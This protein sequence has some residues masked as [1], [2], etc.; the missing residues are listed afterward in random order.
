MQLND[1]P[2]KDGRRRRRRRRGGRNRGGG[3]G[4]QKNQNQ[5]RPPR[6]DPSDERFAG[7]SA[8]VPTG[9]EALDQFN[10]FCAYHLGITR[11]DGYK[12]QSVGE[13]ARRFAV[14]PEVIKTKL[15]QFHLQTESLRERGFDGEMAQLDIRVAP[16]GVSRRALARDI[17]DELEIPEALPDPEPVEEETVEEELVDEADEDVVAEAD[18]EDATEEVEAEAEADDE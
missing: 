8:E 7:R 15:V 2:R 9:P 17:F 5:N 3:R 10:L 14:S 1:G 6:I 16:E 4:G 12:F 13:V 11:T 18:E